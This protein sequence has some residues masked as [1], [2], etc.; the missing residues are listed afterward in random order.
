MKQLKLCLALL[1]VP[2]LFIGCNLLA[3]H[4]IEYNTGFHYLLGLMALGLA[5]SFWAEYTLPYNKDWNRSKGDRRRDG[6]HF[7]VNESMTHVGL[8]ILP[9]LPSLALFPTLWPGHWPFWLQVLFAVVVLDIVSTLFHYLSHKRA[10]FWRF[11]AV[12]HSVQ[13][14]YGVNGIMKHPVFQLADAMIAVGPLVLIGMPQDIGFALV[15]AVFIQLLVQHSNVDIKTGWLKHVYASAEV[16]RYHHLKGR[17]GDVNFALFFSLWDHWL[18]TFH[19]PAQALRLTDRNLGIGNE[20]DYPVDYW[21]QLKRPF[22]FQRQPL[23][24]SPLPAKTAQT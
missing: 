19:Y 14:L 3:F 16:H 18:G 5:F 11:H 21:G 15:F 12:H 4:I 20:P 13:R 23:D 9:L 1:Y 6:Y 10:F 7:V 8:L 17:D 24:V 22:R 2:T